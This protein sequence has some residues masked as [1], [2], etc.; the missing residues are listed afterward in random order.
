MIWIVT[1]F[2]WDKILEWMEN[3]EAALR[4]RIPRKTGMSLR[5]A[6]RDTKKEEVENFNWVFFQPPIPFVLE[7]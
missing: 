3:K 2:V 4:E 5:T 7:E 1:E 6:S